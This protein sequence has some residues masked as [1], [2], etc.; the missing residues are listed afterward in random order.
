LDLS[1]LSPEALAQLA[2]VTDGR[3]RAAPLLGLP[4]LMKALGHDPERV[5]QAA[6]IDPTFFD[7]PENV[8]EFR[9]GARLLA[10]AADCTG[11]PDLGLLLGRSKGLDTIGLVGMLARHS[12]DVGS[13][14]RNLVLHLLIH[15]RGAVSTLV[16]AGEQA[17]LAYAIYQPG[18]E[19]ACHVYDL[20]MAMARN[21]LKDL[22]GPGW[23]PI[24]VRLPHRRPPD[25]ES[26]RRFFE[27]PVR[28]DAERAA[29]VFPVAWLKH[30]IQGADPV[31]Y[32]QLKGR[33]AA[34]ESSADRDILSWARPVLRNLVLGGGGSLE[35]VAESF[36]V[37]KRTL[38]RRMRAMGT[39]F[40]DLVEEVRYDVACQLLME[41]DLPVTEI[42]AVLDYAD[43]GSL[44]RAF[45]RWSGTTPRAWRAARVP[46]D[47]KPVGR[48]GG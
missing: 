25:V 6:G 19:G 21:I 44:T 26:F 1:R 17:L 20:A 4:E 36:A 29:V 32:R 45:R 14:L 9:H 2:P 24:E 41:T 40:Q 27:V 48:L 34:L 33:I 18:V 37:H 13:A 16:I 7:H 12:P 47:S 5:I 8:I 28:F 42:A 30:P 46:R 11:R 39:T 43:A 3:I 10:S 15:D 23:R 38:N 22:C 35:Q 31:L